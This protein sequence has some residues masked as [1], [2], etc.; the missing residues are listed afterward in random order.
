MKIDRSHWSSQTGGRDGTLINGIKNALENMEKKFT[1]LSRLKFDDVDKDLKE[2]LQEQKIQERPFAY[3]FYH[4]FRK[5]YDDGSIKDY[6]SENIIP[7][8][9]VHKGYQKIPNLNKMPDF[10]LHKTGFSTN[11][12]VIE[13]KLASNLGQI[14]D[15]F[16]KLTKFKKIGPSYSVEYEYLIEVVVGNGSSLERARKHINQLSGSTGEEIIVIE[17]NTDSWKANDFR[18]KYKC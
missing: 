16:E 5:F 1:D 2:K 10:I 4:Q 7:Q 14:K 18:I 8:A 13:F 15:D 12:A 6:I 9:E 17:F 3:E 11:L